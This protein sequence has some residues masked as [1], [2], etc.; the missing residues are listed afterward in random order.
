MLG[1]TM[2]QPR[3][4]CRDGGISV[5]A[6]SEFHQ[7][8]ELLGRFLN[9]HGHVLNLA[10][11]FSQGTDCLVLWSRTIC[12]KVRYELIDHGLDNGLLRGIVIMQCSL[13]DP[14]CVGDL[15]G[16]ETFEAALRNETESDSCDLGP[17]VVCF[18]TRL[19]RLSDGVF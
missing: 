18:G 3:E 7:H 9:A 1:K 5:C 11:E 16:T 6:Q 19:V 14:G 10:A 2:V 13:V 15:S 4:D 8:P 17:P 12:S